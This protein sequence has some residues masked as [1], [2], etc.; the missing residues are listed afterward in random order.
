MGLP[1]AVALHSVGFDCYGFD[2]RPSAEFPT[3]ADRMLPSLNGL[4]A[5]DTLWVVVRDQYQI[6][7]I[8]FGEFAVFKQ[9]DYP[10]LLVVS[11][12]VSPKYIAKL[13]Q[14]LPEDVTFVD[15]PMS[16]AP[17]AAIE[18]TLTFMIGGDES[19]VNQLMPAFNA[20]GTTTHYLG[21]TGQGMFAKV[22][23]NYVA[24]CNV[25][26]V[27]KSLAHAK[28]LGMPPQKLLDVINSSSGGNWFSSKLDAIDWSHED[29]Q[30]DNTFGIL[31]KDVTAALDVIDE[32][33]S[34]KDNFG[35]EMVSTLRQ[36]PSLPDL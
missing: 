22:L 8:C 7:D 19:A 21:K 3:F 33:Y 29:Y 5:E 31:E 10:K 2:V 6:D 34:D 1:M 4:L 24:A 28:E 12:T 20:M 15:A 14:S 32:L 17:V 18:K 30:P 13:K 36:I 11:S 25:I 27:R 23:N 16:G 9:P 35:H 26:S